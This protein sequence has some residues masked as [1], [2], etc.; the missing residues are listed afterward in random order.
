M[1]DNIRNTLSQQLLSSSETW[2]KPLA[3][4]PFHSKA[5]IYPWVLYAL[6]SLDG[7]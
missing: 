7:C 3:N 4:S 2:G 5:E 1:K 6:D